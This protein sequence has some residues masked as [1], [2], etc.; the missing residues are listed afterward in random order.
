MPSP[1]A[2]GVP[3]N[4]NRME[5]RNGRIDR[6]GQRFGTV[7]IFHFASAAG[8][9]H[10]LGQDHSF[11]SRLA[12][13]VNDIRDEL[14]SVSSVLAER[15]EARMLRDGNPSLDV[16]SLVTEW[17]DRA[18]TDLERI[19]QEFSADIARIREQYRT[20]IDELDLTPTSVQRAV[21]VALRI[22][23]QP[24]LRPSNLER[25]GGSVQV[26]AIDDLAG[27]WGETLAGLRNE[28]EDFRLS[29]TFD[30]EIA[31]GH[32]DVAYLHLG[33]PLV[34]RYLRT[35]RAQVW[36]ASVDRK[37]NRVTVRYAAV[38]E[39]V[40]VAHARVVINGADGS[41]LDEVIEPAA[42][43]VG[44]RQGRFNVGETRAAVAFAGSQPVPGHVCDLYA[45]QWSR[46]RTPLQDALEA[47]AQEVLDQRSRR[48]NDKRTR[49]EKR[50]RGTLTDLQS[51]IERRLNEL[52]QS[53][54]RGAV[55]AVRYGRAPAVRC[56]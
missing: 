11:L 49:E 56:R 24:P 53:R 22:E 34:A 30:P 40:A 43:R 7:D 36:G 32:H 35:L 3:F 37:I 54:A 41:I 19:K 38:T 52:E 12:T 29:V 55:K 15:V 6:H 27:T 42:V 2:H 18:R 28:V 17:H 51:S 9:D 8:E 4:P 1:R 23:N 14:G 25:A 31:N 33:H 5:Q 44:G 13:K 45:D 21:E 46:V 10:T 47:R 20:S 16:D 26:F 48:M 39:P 50:L